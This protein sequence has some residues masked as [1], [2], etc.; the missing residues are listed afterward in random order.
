MAKADENS[1]RS[2]L[3]R[4]VQEIEAQRAEQ[5][6]LKQSIAQLEKRRW[7]TEPSQATPPKAPPAESVPPNSLPSA[8]APPPLP[9]PPAAEPVADRLRLFLR[10][11]IDSEH[12][13]RIVTHT[14]T[15][16]QRLRW[17]LDSIDRGVVGVEGFLEGLREARVKA[18][19]RT[20][21]G[22]SQTLGALPRDALMEVLRSPQV[23]QLLTSVVAN[24][25]Y[26]GTPG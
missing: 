21:Q 19:D 18:L 6:R 24:L 7:E 25:L 9:S 1:L 17:G 8:S 4:L 20:A 12:L 26:G 13:P 14:H 10:G 15:Y 22:V 16:S 3:D 5:V 11:L 23:R 2:E